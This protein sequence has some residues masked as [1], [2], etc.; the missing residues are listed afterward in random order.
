MDLQGPNFSD[1]SDPIF[2]D[3][4]EPIFNSND[5]NRETKEFSDF[6]HSN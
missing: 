6:R 5:P 2:F 4:R 1:S 3:S